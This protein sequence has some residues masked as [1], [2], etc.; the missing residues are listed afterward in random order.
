MRLHRRPT[1]ALQAR[2]L[3][4]AGAAAAGTA[5]VGDGEGGAAVAAAAPE[6]LPGDSAAA[7]QLSHWLSVDVPGA[8]QQGVPCYADAGSAASTS[9]AAPCRAARAACAELCMVA[10]TG[11]MHAAKAPMGAP[12]L[13]G[14]PEAPSGDT[15]PQQQLDPGAGAAKMELLRLC[16]RQVAGSLDDVVGHE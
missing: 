15:W 2:M 12:Q 8:M 3:G 16:Q 11:G 6:P 9:S 13:W 4:G 7:A 1:Q 5:P 10:C 14:A